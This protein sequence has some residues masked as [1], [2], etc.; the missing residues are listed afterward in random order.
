MDTSNEVSPS[1]RL[2]SCKE[3]EKQSC[4][5]EHSVIESVSADRYL[6]DS[7]FKVEW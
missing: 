5:T 2:C 7:F 4:V 6:Y 1:A 3:K